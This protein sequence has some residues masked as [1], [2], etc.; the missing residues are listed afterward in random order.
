VGTSFA[1]A[2]NGSKQGGEIFTATNVHAGLWNGTAASFVDLNPGGATDSSVRALSAS[3]QVGDAKIGGVTRAAVWTG[4]AGSFTDLTP[5]AATGGTLWATTGLQQAGQ[6][7]IGGVRHAG[8]WSGTA[9]SF[10]D[11]HPAGY[12]ESAIYDTTGT[13]QVGFAEV[14]GKNH[15]G[16][17]SGTA[18]SFVDLHPSGATS[19]QVNATIGV[20]QAGTV[21][22]SGTDHAAVWAGTAASFLDLQAYMPA[23]YTSSSASSIS[24]DGDLDRVS[25][26]V[27]GS[28]FNATP[29]RDA[30]EPRSMMADMSV[31]QSA[32]ARPL[33][34]VTAS[35]SPSLRFIAKP[36][37]VTKSGRAE[38]IRCNR[39][40]HSPAATS[41]VSTST[42]GNGFQVARR[43][44]PA[45]STVRLV[46]RTR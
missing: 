46:S 1:F 23:A 29:W 42:S 33:S 22:F 43:L 3:Q 28:A 37:S 10:V 31:P 26:L 5:A 19:S 32:V 30:L 18:A 45:K 20:R 16:L 8:L 17:W 11:V 7:I 41:V 27:A 6:A 15:A 9:N 25:I 14:S 24:T 12:A 13:Q 4:T 2:S 21:N 39:I 35:R 36:P 34:S 38:V 44:V 40:C